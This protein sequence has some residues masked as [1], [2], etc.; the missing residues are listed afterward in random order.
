M[1]LAD[2]LVTVAENIPKV[3]QSGKNAEWNTF[4]DSYQ[5]SG[6]RTNYEY[7]FYNNCWD[8]NNF[9]PKYNIVPVYGANL[10]RA[11]AITDLKGILEKNEV[12]LDLSK[13]SS[14]S[15][16]HLFRLSS[17]TRLPEINLT[18]PTALSYTFRDAT[19][20]VSIDKLILKSDGSQTFTETFVGASALEEIRIE[21]SVG[22]SI[23]FAS[24][25]KLTKESLLSII[26]ALKTYTSGTYTLTLGTTNLAKL[27]DDEKAV[28]TGKGW[29]LA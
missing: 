29:K 22:N 7:A 8:D 3:Y 2:K 14:T 16:G 10:F 24:C 18:T 28:A 27:T 9:K 17:I 21:G 5:N 1:S 20:L 15:T 12:V 26:N 23:S 19:K 13:L 6:T 11:C 25:A 4:W